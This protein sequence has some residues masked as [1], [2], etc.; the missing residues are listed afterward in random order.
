MSIGRSKSFKKI[1]KKE[2]KKEIENEYE[3]MWRY[4]KTIEHEEIEEKR[5]R[6]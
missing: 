2:R 3:F 6:D 4:R 1:R 5:T